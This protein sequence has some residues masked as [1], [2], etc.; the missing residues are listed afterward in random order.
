MGK[1]RALRADEIEVRVSNTTQKGCMLLLYKDARCDKRILD[2]M[3]TP[4]GWQ[5]RYEEIKGNLYCSVGVL[6]PE[7]GTWVWKQDCGVESN[8][9]K[10]KGEASDAFKRA[11]FNWGIGR[12]LYTKIFIWIKASDVPVKAND[13]GKYVLSDPFTKFRVTEVVTDNEREKITKLRISASS[14]GAEKE[15]FV[16]DENKNNNKSNNK[17]RVPSST[18]SPVKKASIDSLIRAVSAS[19]KCDEITVQRLVEK[20]INK[21]FG[22]ITDDDADTVMSLL[23]TQIEKIKKNDARSNA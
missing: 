7:T 21:P 22:E 13:K 2:E 19:Y 15:V 3:Y 5:D 14:G 23:H 4:M 20:Y 1:I 9:E 16:Y 18:L 11:C 12:E 17:A 10:E 8:A 6:N